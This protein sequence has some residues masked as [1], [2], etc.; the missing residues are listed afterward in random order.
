MKMHFAACKIALKKSVKQL[1]PQK[2]NQVIVRDHCTAKKEGEKKI[3][4]CNK[5]VIFQTRDQKPKKN[6]A[7]AVKR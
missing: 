2:V 6:G 4:F 1:R 3:M 5:N 7:P